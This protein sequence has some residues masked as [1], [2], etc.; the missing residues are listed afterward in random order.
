MSSQK[1]CPRQIR[2]YCWGCA[3]CCTHFSRGKFALSECLL[4]SSS[5]GFQF[6]ICEKLLADDLFLLV[7]YTT[8]WHF[9]V[10]VNFCGRSRS[11]VSN[12]QPRIFSRARHLSILTCKLQSEMLVS[13]SSNYFQ[14]SENGGLCKKKMA[15]VPQ[16][17]NFCWNSWMIVSFKM[18]EIQGEDGCW[19]P[20]FRLLFCFCWMFTSFRKLQQ[21]QQQLLQVWTPFSFLYIFLPFTY[22]S[23][24]IV[25]FLRDFNTVHIFVFAGT[26]S[27]YVWWTV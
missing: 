20:D 2:I 26:L 24:C 4:L 13:Q 12:E 17:S 18:N 11:G 25:C 22:L 14:A 27:Y 1:E 15:V 19:Q 7:F 23:S 6:S 9:G 10:S 3:P 5:Y 8:S 21:V 16:R